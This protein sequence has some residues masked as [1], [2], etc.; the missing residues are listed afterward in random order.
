LRLREAKPLRWAAASG[1]ETALG[2][3]G[4]AACAHR[5][6]VLRGRDGDWMSGRARTLRS[7][8]FLRA[9]A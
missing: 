2:V 5:T 3:H 6:D 7:R 4:R 1:S 9:R 8:G